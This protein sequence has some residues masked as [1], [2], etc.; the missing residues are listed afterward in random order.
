MK[1]YALLNP[2]NGTYTYYETIDT[3]QA[4]LVKRMFDFYRLQVHNTLYSV[5][6]VDEVAGTETWR[7]PTG[8]LELSPAQLL[9]ELGILLREHIESQQGQ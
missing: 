9:S 3:L 8:E 5:V 4:A 7:S 6:D 2:S 1:K